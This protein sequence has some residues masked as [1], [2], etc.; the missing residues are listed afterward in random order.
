MKRII[1]LVV[2]VAMIA[3]V[4]S[5]A[6]CQASTGC[7]DSVKASIKTLNDSADVVVLGVSYKETTCKAYTALQTYYGASCTIAWK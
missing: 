6:S 4:S 2:A 5:C 3:F 7:S 1:A